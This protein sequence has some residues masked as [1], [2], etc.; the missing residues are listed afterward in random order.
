[1]AHLG[2]KAKTLVKT[3]LDVAVRKLEHFALHIVKSDSLLL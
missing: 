2:N 1:M 3:T